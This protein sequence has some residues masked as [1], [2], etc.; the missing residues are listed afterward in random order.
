MISDAVEFIRKHSC[1]RTPSKYFGEFSDFEEVPVINRIATIDKLRFKNRIVR[2]RILLQAALLSYWDLQLWLEETNY[3]QL[4]L[5]TCISFVDPVE[6][7]EE[8][9]VAIPNIFMTQKNNEYAFDKAGKPYIYDN[10][11]LK[12][13]TSSLLPS[14]HFFSRKLIGKHN[15][16]SIERLIFFPKHKQ[17]SLD[18]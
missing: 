9:G 6:D 2:S 17:Y 14:D 5:F 8:Y 7:L 16:E 11:T 10:I 15:I 13:I 1:I 12:E 3:P 18:P 4:N